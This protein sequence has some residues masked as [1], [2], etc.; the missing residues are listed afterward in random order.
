MNSLASTKFARRVLMALAAVSGIFLAVGCGS[1]S[2]IGTPNPTGFGNSNL[3]GTYDFAVSGT[4]ITSTSES[5]F[6]ITGTIAA[7][8]KGNI[9]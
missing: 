5:F 6:A 7:D 4:D 8:G 3:S 2:G 1:S 9:T